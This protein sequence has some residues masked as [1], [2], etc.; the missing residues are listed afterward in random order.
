MATVNISLTSSYGKATRLTP[1]RLHCW[2]LPL[3]HW[4]WPCATPGLLSPIPRLHFPDDTGFLMWSAKP[5][6]SA[7]VHLTN[8]SPSPG[9]GC[10]TP[11]L[12]MRRCENLSDLPQ[13]TSG[14]GYELCCLLDIVVF[15]PPDQK[16]LGS[17][18]PSCF[19]L[20]FLR[21]ELVLFDDMHAIN[22]P[23]SR[24]WMI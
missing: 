4:Y 14:S 11:I 24:Q 7:S 15:S 23:N 6:M 20:P 18:P 12:W 10:K 1:L 22:R 19:H 13:V 8:L 2:D 21:N 16:F 9:G 5:F 17:G 3:L